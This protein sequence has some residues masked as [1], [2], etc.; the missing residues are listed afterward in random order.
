M[1][2]HSKKILYLATNPT[3]DTVVTGAADCM[4]KFWRPY[5]NMKFGSNGSELDGGD[6]R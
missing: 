1:V 2:G 6:L 5:K 4:I 3:G